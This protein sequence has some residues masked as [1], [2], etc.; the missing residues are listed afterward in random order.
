MASLVT[1]QR[2]IT[3]V[4][5]EGWRARFV[6]RR[7]ERRTS[8]TAATVIFVRI[9][10]GAGR[11]GTTTSYSIREVIENKYVALSYV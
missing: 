11:A 9:V 4:M 8:S 7:S 10:R 2:K 5:K 3:R 6:A 1:N